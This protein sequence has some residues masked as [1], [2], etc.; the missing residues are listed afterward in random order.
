MKGLIT[1]IFLGITLWGIEGKEVSANDWPFVCESSNLSFLNNKRYFKVAFS[2]DGSY[3]AIMADTK[4]IQIDRKNKI[5]KV[6]TIWLASDK[7]RLDRIESFRKFDDCSNFGYYKALNTI[8]YKD[9][10]YTHVKFIQNNCDGSALNTPE[11][12]SSWIDIGPDSVVETIMD[13][14]VKKYNLK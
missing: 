13:S 10:K 1:F 8:N 6:W 7:G 11:V 14:I 4:T 12:Q 5:I 9:M 3:P 2:G